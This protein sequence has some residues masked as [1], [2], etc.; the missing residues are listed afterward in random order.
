[1]SRAVQDAHV[2]VALAGWPHTAGGVTTVVVVTNVVV[3]VVLDVVLCAATLAC[4]ELY[5][6]AP[7]P[8]SI[9]STASNANLRMAL[10]RGD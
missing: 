9:A 4:R 8:I 7:S 5:M 2:D 10:S 1:V 6:Y 3:V